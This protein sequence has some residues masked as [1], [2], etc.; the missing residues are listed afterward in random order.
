MNGR[1]GVVAE[2]ALVMVVLMLLMMMVVL[3]MMLVMMVVVTK[4]TLLTMS[5]AFPLLGCVAVWVCF[6]DWR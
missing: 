2:L 5:A 3:V 1:V 4:T 6:C